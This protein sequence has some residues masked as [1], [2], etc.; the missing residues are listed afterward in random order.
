MLASLRAEIEST[1]NGNIQLVRGLV[2]VIATDP[3]IDAARFDAIASALI[4]ERSQLRNIAAAPDLVIRFMYPLAGNEAAVGLSYLTNPA[5]RDAALAAMRAREMVLAGPVDLVQG[6]RGF[7]GRLPVFVDDPSFEGDV[8]GKRPWGLVSA[9][10]DVTRFYEASGLLRED[11]PLR[12]AL[13]GIDSD[14]EDAR[15]FFGDAAVLDEDPVVADVSLPA[16]GWRIA[17][18]PR[19]GWTSTP[20]GVVHFRLVL[21]L[22]GLAVIVPA[23]V[24][25]ILYDRHRRQARELAVREREL[26]ILSRRLGLALET[27]RIGV[28]ELDLETGELRWDERM[29]ELYGA[30]ARSSA[31]MLDDWKDGVHPEDRDRVVAAFEAAVRDETTYTAEFRVLRPDGTW[32]WVRAIGAIHRD[33]SGHRLALGVNWDVSDD[34]RRKMQLVEANRSAEARN[35]DL[36]DARRQ[37]EQASLHDSLTGL[38]N[39]R[40]LDERIG[41]PGRPDPSAILHVDLDRFKQIN[42]T[43][44]HAAGDAMLVHAAEVLRRGARAGDVVARVGGDEFVVAVMSAVSPAGL[45]ALAERIIGEMSRPVPYQNHECRFGASI[46]IAVN[47]E[48]DTSST[49][50]LLID[51]DLALY[52]AKN[53]GRNRFEFFDASLKAEVVAHKT[54]ADEI[55]GGLERR[56]FVAFFQPQFDARTLDVVGVEA[57]ARWRHPT[58]GLLAPAAFL[59]TAEDLGVAPLI[60]R[61]ILEE[62]LLQSRRWAAAGVTIPKKSVN[63][64]AGRLKDESLIDGLRDLAITPGELSFEL[65][66][67]IFLDDEDAVSKRNIAQLAEMGI[68]IEID[69]FGTGYAS[70]VGLLQLR[71]ARLKIERRL[72]HPIVQSLEQRRLVASIVEIGRSLGIE[73]VGEGVETMEHVSILRDLGCDVL[74]GYAFAT[75][76]S[77]DD[78]AHFVRQGS[79]RAMAA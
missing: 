77:S 72:V 59:S 64:S 67:T 56:E 13:T 68:S 62:T 49:K 20:E 4:G 53:R 70:I 73:V 18:V 69:D 45:C 23:F 79:W 24:A 66:E 16:G 12:V 55:L 21:L 52:R 54:L 61:A 30:P 31:F 43:L 74:Q 5:Q 47:E 10:I 14:P 71:P 51:A 40:F 39:R 38:P 42:D 3:T 19:G 7:I 58:R 50:Q 41:G 8:A 76:M 6:G 9:V 48:S 65:L 15:V 37:M 32:S 26:R 44:G 2:A 63:V 29:K 1:I 28:W 25:G 57:L 17:A 11:L 36:E 46:G 75:P 78:L 35:A 60:D 27:S 22:A 33:A 34:V